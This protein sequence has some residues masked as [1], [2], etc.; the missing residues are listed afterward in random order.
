MPGEVGGHRQRPLD[1]VSFAYTL[2]SAEEATR[3][4]LQYFEMLGHRAIWADGWKAVATHWSARMLQFV[5]ETSHD[6][7]DGDFDADRWELYHLD[8]DFS[9]CCLLYTS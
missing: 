4:R 7:H 5:P 1:G 9:E 6:L 2:R 8:D 3:K